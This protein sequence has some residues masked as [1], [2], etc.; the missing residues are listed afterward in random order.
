MLSCIS[1]GVLHARSGDAYVID[2]KG[3]RSESALAELLPPGNKLMNIA[4]ILPVLQVG[5][6][7][8]RCTEAA[9]AVFG[10]AA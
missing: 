3:A 10:K 2:V 8:L 6:L 7:L 1:R 9:R 5:H 4:K